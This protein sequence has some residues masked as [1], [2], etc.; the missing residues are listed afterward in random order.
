MPFESNQNENMSKIKTITVNSKKKTSNTRQTKP[1]LIR[2]I[3][4]H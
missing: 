4:K 2:M 1:N 3:E